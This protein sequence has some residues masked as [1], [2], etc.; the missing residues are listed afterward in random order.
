MACCCM[1]PAPDCTCGGCRCTCTCAKGLIFPQ[2]TRFFSP[3]PFCC[4]VCN[5]SGTVQ[6]PPEV[7]GDQETWVNSSAYNEYTCK[8]CNGEGIVWSKF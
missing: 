7:A 5:G 1:G 6:R 3:V 2:I 4:P 8:A